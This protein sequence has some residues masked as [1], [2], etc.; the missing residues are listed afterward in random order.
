MEDGGSSR[1]HTLRDNG[2][3]LALNFSLCR[4][5]V[6]WLTPSPACITDPNDSAQWMWSGAPQID[7]AH[8]P[9]GASNTDFRRPRGTLR[10][11]QGHLDALSA[12]AQ[13]ALVRLPHCNQ[14]HGASGGFLSSTRAHSHTRTLASGQ[15]F[16][17]LST[18]S[19]LRRR[20]MGKTLE[21][22][23]SHPRGRERERDNAQRRIRWLARRPNDL[24]HAS[25]THLLI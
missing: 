8:T 19:S 18:P 21:F 10:S 9:K 3:R 20:R 14:A 15:F 1:T 11:A 13:T 12:T 4:G 23:L 17:K 25:S 7:H 16:S 2:A 22:D 5:F 6:C 24:W